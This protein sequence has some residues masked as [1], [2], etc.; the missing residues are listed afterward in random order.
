MSKDILDKLV[1][2]VM[3]GKVDSFRC[4]VLIVFEKKENEDKKKAID[5]PIIYI[6]HLIFQPSLPSDATEEDIKAQE[7]LVGYKFVKAKKDLT[8]IVHPDTLAWRQKL[9]AEE[10]KK[11][12]PLEKKKK[13]MERGGPPLSEEEKA[14]FEEYSKNE[15]LLKE[16]LLTLGLS[17]ELSRSIGRVC[18]FSWIGRSTMQYK[19]F[20]I[21]PVAKL[22]LLFSTYEISQDGTFEY[23]RRYTD[24]F[25]LDRSMPEL[26]MENLF[27]GLYKKYNQFSNEYK[28]IHV[29]SSD[30]N[31]ENV[32][33]LCGIWERICNDDKEIEKN[34]QIDAL[35][36][37]VYV[38]IGLF[39]RE[40]GEFWIKDS[41]YE[42]IKQRLD[43]AKNELKSP[44]DLNKIPDKFKDRP[45]SL[46]PLEL[47]VKTRKLDVVKLLL[48][49]GAVLT[50][51]TIAYAINQRQ[52][53]GKK[54]QELKEIIDYLVMY[55]KRCLKFR[56]DLLSATKELLDEAKKIFDLSKPIIP[57]DDK[58]NITPLHLLL[59]YCDFRMAEYL[60]R[61]CKIN[62]RERYG[63]PIR[64]VQ[65]YALKDKDLCSTI[66]LLENNKFDSDDELSKK[67]LSWWES[68][69]EKSTDFQ[70]K[71]FIVEFYK[72]ARTIHTEIGENKKLSLYEPCCSDLTE[73][74]IEIFKILEEWEIG[75]ENPDSL[76]KLHEVINPMI[77][78]LSEI[79][80]S[81]PDG[82]S[83]KSSLSK[84]LFI[85][86]KSNLSLSEKL[87]NALNKFEESKKLDKR[88]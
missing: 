6:P 52:K 48:E 13:E 14:L 45:A 57:I 15:Y 60:I 25:F 16:P 53:F 83:P 71:E 77:S 4:A 47:A 11:R 32:S 9:A 26:G 21:H 54:D 61:E 79:E 24:V 84:S 73:I 85:Q 66:F 67:L 62:V 63:D 88:L 81:S 44:L 87:Q 31:S 75:K 40:P 74:N 68:K 42:I 22:C 18:V 10:I 64:T 12:A 33:R 17:C 59:G 76:K 35:E 55:R 86:N 69:E 70:L 28:I 50:P 65:S 51:S 80:K 30:P 5:N 29:E 2:L 1:R 19:L 46:P 72:I 58:N 3:T 39:K 8:G 38:A 78:K 56:S 82:L 36:V 37:S 49:N 41:D 27:M 7:A 20:E 23:G 43:Y 34:N